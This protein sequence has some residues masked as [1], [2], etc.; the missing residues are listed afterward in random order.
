MHFNQT[1]LICGI[2]NGNNNN[3]DHL[4]CSHTFEEHLQNLLEESNVIQESATTSHLIVKLKATLSFV[5]PILVE[6]VEADGL[7]PNWWLQQNLAK[8]TGCGDETGVGSHH[9][10]QYPSTHLDTATKANALAAILRAMAFGLGML[11]H[12]S[13]LLED[14][15]T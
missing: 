2:T 11:Q 9:F 4:E 14:L 12:A 5:Q 1:I 13:T 7:G 15:A 6:V 3:P 10:S 8:Q